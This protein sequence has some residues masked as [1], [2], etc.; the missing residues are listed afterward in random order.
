MTY[1]TLKYRLWKSVKHIQFAVHFNFQ[2]IIF[3]TFYKL[4]YLT[5]IYTINTEKS[6]AFGQNHFY[7]AGA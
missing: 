3:N 2:P 4:S 6:S 7:V 1:F 5:K